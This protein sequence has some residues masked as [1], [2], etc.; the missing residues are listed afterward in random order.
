M[1]TQ[2][3]M[4]FCVCRGRNSLNIN[5]SRKCFE[6]ISLTIIKT[7]IS[8]SVRRFSRPQFSR[9]SNEWEESRQNCYA[10][11]LENVGTSTSHNPMGLHDLL[12]GELYLYRDKLSF[13]H[14]GPVVGPFK[15]VTLG[16]SLEPDRR[17]F[18]TTAA[19]Y[20]TIP[21]HLKTPS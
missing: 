21:K 12:Q 14:L 15:Y 11:C 1:N 3:Y 9:P 2:T 4:R 10:D 7:R 5:P 17:I 18:R 6:K 19:E 13:R 20:V 8:W 16:T